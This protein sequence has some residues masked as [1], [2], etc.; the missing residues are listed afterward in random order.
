MSSKSVAEKM[1]LKPG[2]NI[3]F[4]NAPNNLKKLLGGFPDGVEIAEEL[5]GSELDFVL[6]F[7]E[8]QKMLEAYLGSLK[9]AIKDNG[10][11][12]LAYIKGSSSM[13]TDINRDS[14]HQFATSQNL[15][16]V[17]MVSI[18]DDWSGFRFKK[19]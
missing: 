5:E 8:N 2:M 15:K 10:A 3:G 1:Y 12:W 14:I 16:G 4:L 19:I 11:L 9:N 7:I 18:N 17:A 6:A 13:E